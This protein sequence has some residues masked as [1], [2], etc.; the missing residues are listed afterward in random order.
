MYAG[1]IVLNKPIFSALDITYFQSDV[2]LICAWVFSV[3]HR[4]NARKIKIMLV[5]MKHVKMSLQLMAGSV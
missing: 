3:H 5:S 4:L 2:D 1:D